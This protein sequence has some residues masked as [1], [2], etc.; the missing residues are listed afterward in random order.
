M[1]AG[2]VGKPKAPIV[3]KGGSFIESFGNVLER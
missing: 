2:A 3:A 1:F